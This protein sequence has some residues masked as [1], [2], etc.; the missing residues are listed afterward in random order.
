VFPT[1]SEL[2]NDLRA[3]RTSSEALVGACIERIG[4][5]NPTLN[6]VIALDADRALDHARQADAD[7]RAGKVVGPLHGLPITC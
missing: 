7:L 6:A 2:I 3:G 4:R 5:F 1:A